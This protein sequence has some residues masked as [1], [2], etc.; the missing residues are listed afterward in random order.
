MANL[1]QS[2]GGL[3]A[4]THEVKIELSK[5][6]WPS[7]QELMGST[8]VVIVSCILLAAYVGVCDVVL[9]NLLKLIAR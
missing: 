3:K 6:N 1:G 8:M 4:F 5:C 7:R 9:M 2:I